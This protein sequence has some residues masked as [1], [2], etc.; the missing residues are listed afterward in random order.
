[1]K[2]IFL[3]FLSFFTYFL[4]NYTTL[5]PEKEFYIALKHTNTDILEN[6]LINISDPKHESYGDYLTVE[7]IN[8]RVAVDAPEG[9]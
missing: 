1:M 7:Q 2:N 3:I 6:T 8:S 4:G 9:C 5:N